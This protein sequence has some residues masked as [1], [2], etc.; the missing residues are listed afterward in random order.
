MFTILKNTRI[1]NTLCHNRLP[2][3]FDLLCNVY[4]YT[5]D[6]RL[7]GDYIALAKS[8]YSNPTVDY[9]E[10]FRIK[11]NSEPKRCEI[12]LFIGS[13][14]KKRSTHGNRTEDV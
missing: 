10:I 12:K 7:F 3:F 14:N 11:S 4:V 6:L 2:L 9:P 5:F 1:I 13:Q 8:N